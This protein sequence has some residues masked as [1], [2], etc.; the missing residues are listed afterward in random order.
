VMTVPSTALSDFALSDLTT[1]LSISAAGRTRINRIDTSP[2]FTIG[3][4]VVD[5]A[6]RTVSINWS[7]FPTGASISGFT[8]TAV[9]TGSKTFT[10]AG[11]K[12]GFFDGISSLI[13]A[14]STGNDGKYTL[15]SMAY[16]GGNTVITVQE[17]PASSTADGT[18]AQYDDTKEF[19]YDV[20]V[21]VPRN[22]TITA[23]STGSKTFTMSGDQR[24]WFNVG[25]TITVTGSTGNDGTYTVTVINYTGGNTVLTVT[26]TVPSAVADGSVRVTFKI[27]VIKGTLTVSRQEDRT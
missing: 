16:T 9:S 2:D 3:A 12:R 5:A 6:A 15:V 23:V 24:R 26:E 10:M 21:T 27:T 22:N 8:I 4:A 1:V 14:N 13:V 20:Q 11:D 25:G 18:L 19:L 7:S 17:T